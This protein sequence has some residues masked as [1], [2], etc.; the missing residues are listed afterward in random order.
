MA[1]FINKAVKRFAMAGL[2]IKGI[3]YRIPGDVNEYLFRDFSLT[4]GPGEHLGIMGPNGCGKTTLFNMIAGICKPCSGGISINGSTPSDSSVAYIF[5]DYRSS[6]FPW[7]TV[8]ENILLPLKIRKTGKKLMEKKLEY[9]DSL[10]A[11]SLDFS[12]YPYQLSGGQQQFIVILRGLVMEPSV[13]LFDEPFSA[14]DRKNTEWLI[15]KISGLMGSSLIPALTVAHDEQ[16]LT[17]LCSRIVFVE[18]KPLRIVRDLPVKTADPLVYRIS[19]LNYG[20]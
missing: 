12:K 1:C 10:N 9:V 17:E 20:A 18:G 6:L 2:D 8:K 11:C 16:H 15:N 13:V 14:L 5:Q 7:Y 4:T 19:R 3:S